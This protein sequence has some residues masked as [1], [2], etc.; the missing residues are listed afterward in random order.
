MTTYRRP[1]LHTYTW[2]KLSKQLRE[3]Q[4]WCSIC[5]KTD[6]LSVD[7]VGGGRG[8]GGPLRVVCR[9]CNSTLG[10]R[11]RARG[12]GGGQRARPPVPPVVADQTPHRM[13]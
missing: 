11:A 3:D 4:P 8:L 9:G 12:T 5:G 7:H 6:D 13:A 10:N 2:R 1:D